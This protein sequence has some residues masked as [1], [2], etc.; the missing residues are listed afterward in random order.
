[1]KK[2]WESLKKAK[3]W[4]LL[5]LMWGSFGLSVYYLPTLREFA[6]LSFGVWMEPLTLALFPGSILSL[7]VGESLLMMFNYE[8][9]A[10]SLILSLIYL[11]SA[12]VGAFQWYI[13]YL[14]FQALKK[15]GEKFRPKAAGR[16]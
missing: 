4:I 12:V 2:F 9:P 10:R 14:I 16:K 11:V 7:F 5:G 13:L 8:E 1:M 3:W 6:Y 15:I